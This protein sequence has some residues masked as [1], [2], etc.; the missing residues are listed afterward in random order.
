MDNIASI[1]INTNKKFLE[2]FLLANDLNLM[3][4]LIDFYYNEIN[5]ILFTNQFQGISLSFIPN[6]NIK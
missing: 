1:F 5:N 2:N 6:I 3:K 4:I